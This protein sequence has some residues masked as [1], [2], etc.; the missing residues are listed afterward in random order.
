MIRKIL[1]CLIISNPQSVIM[2]V[3]AKITAVP[4]PAGAMTPFRKLSIIVDKYLY[5]IIYVIHMILY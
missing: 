1:K 5:F 2:I 4:S 3:D